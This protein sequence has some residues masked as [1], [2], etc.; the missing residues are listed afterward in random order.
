MFGHGADMARGTAR[1][2]D[3][4]ITESGAAFQVDGHD[5]LGLVVIQG[6]Q[7]APEQVALRRG[8]FRGRYR[9][10]CGNGR[11]LW[12]GLLGGFYGFL[13]RDFFCF[14]SFWRF[15]LCRLSGS[16]LF[17]SGLLGASQG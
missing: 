7:D 8:L 6:R 15:R 10:L 16:R 3:R 9:F 14:Y 4:R 2:D 13:R 1:G 11:L 5:I 12:C 17:A